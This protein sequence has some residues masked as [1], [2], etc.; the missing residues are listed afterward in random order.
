ML[1]VVETAL[2]INGSRGARIVRGSGR[3]GSP[4]HPS[5]MWIYASPVITVCSHLLSFRQGFR[6]KRSIPN[7]YITLDGLGKPRKHQSG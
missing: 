2:R 7:A 5:E 3:C 1:S 6:R 4:K